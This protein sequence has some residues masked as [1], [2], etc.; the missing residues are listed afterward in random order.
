MKN[1]F[2]NNLFKLPFFLLVV[3][4]I[5]TISLSLVNYFTSSKIKQNGEEAI[6]SAC[7]NSFN[8]HDNYLDFVIEELD[9][10]DN[11]KALGIEGKDVVKD[12][13]NIIGYVYIGSVQGFADKISFVA[14]YE[15]G[16][17]HKLKVTYEQE[18]NKKGINYIKNNY[19]D[20]DLTKPN[21]FETSTYKEGV[22]GASLTGQKGLIKVINECSKDY[23]LT[24]GN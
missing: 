17:F 21:F 7:K 13:D 1:L 4:I 16:K 14:S 23:L 19:V 15:N 2:K 22:A 18:T 11:L 5:C 9:V 10:D 6:K 8:N 24:Y 12:N 20:Y 3:S